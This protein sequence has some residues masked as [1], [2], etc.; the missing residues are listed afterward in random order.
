[1]IGKQASGPDASLFLSLSLYYNTVFYS[2]A[3]LKRLLKLY[4]LIEVFTLL[5]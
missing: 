3:C 2:S 4:F 5:S 1:M